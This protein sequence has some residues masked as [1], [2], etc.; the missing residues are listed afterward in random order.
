MLDKT[1][2]IQMVSQLATV[3]TYIYDGAIQ[4]RSVGFTDVRADR[5]SDALFSHG[6]NVLSKL[7]LESELVARVFDRA[8]VMSGYLNGLQHEVL[9]AYPH[10]FHVHCYAHVLTFSFLRAVTILKNAA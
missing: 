8:S 7:N 6:Q 4:E 3:L 9:K 1:S 5:S 10:A 2:D